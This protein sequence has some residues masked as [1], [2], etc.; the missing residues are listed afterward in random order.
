MW[1]R[2]D[3]PWKRPMS[4]EPHSCQQLMV[5]TSLIFSFAY[6]CIEYFH[7]IHPPSPF[8]PATVTNPLARTCPAFLFS[9][10]VKKNDIFVV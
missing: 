8:P 7:H 2:M 6:M 1:K 9:V 5:S 10:F 4:A 3:R